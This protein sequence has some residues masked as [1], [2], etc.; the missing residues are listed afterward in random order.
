MLGLRQLEIERQ[1]CFASINKDI[2]HVCC[3]VLEWKIANLQNLQWIRLLGQLKRR[4]RKN[5]FPIEA[6]GCLNYIATV[7]RPDISYAV[8]K[9]ARYSNDPQ[10]LHWKSAKRVM[11]YLKGTIDVS[12]YF[13]EESSDAL[14][15]YCDS[16]YAGELEE[17][18]STSIYFSYSW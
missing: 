4:M 14:I 1:G 17:R 16:D 3:I 10:Q 6:I 8:N 9:L 7:S 15:G 11:K 5:V 2:F 13:H 18:R 12:L